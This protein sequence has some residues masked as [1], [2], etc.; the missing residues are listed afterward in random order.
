VLSLLNSV[1]VFVYFVWN[2][3]GEGVDGA[4][5]GWGLV[6]GAIL[7]VFFWYAVSAFYYL[8]YDPQQAAAHRRFG[9]GA[10]R[11]LV[12]PRAWMFLSD[13]NASGSFG[14]ALEDAETSVSF[15]WIRCCF[16]V[17]GYRQQGGN[18]YEGHYLA[19]VAGA[20]FIGLYWLLWPLTAPVPERFWATV[21]LSAY[22]VGALAV[23]IVVLSAKN[24]GNPAKLRVWK[25]LLAIPILGFAVAIPV[26]YQCYDAARFPILALVL[27]LAIATV[28]TLGALAFFLDRY[29]IPVITVILL[30]VFV[31]RFLHWDMGREEHYLSVTAQGPAAPLPTPADIVKNRLTRLLSQ[32]PG[33][34]TSQIQS[35]YLIV[36]TATGGGIHAA[37]WTTEVLRQL[38]EAFAQSPAGDFHDHLLLLSTVSGGS[39]GLYAYL[40][41]VAVARS[42]EKPDWKRM[43]RATKCSSLEAIGWGLVYFDVPKLTVPFGPYLW[44]LS[45]GVDDLQKASF[46]KDRT[47][48]LRKAMARNLNDPFCERAPKAENT[49]AIGDLTQAQ[50]R[51]STDERM[52]TLGQFNPLTGDDPPPAFSMNTTTAEYGA[53]FLSANYQMPPQTPLPYA[54]VP[55]ESF[56]QVYGNVSFPE[57][58]AGRTVDLPLATAAQLSA[59]FPYVSSAARFPFVDGLTSQHFVDGGY[60]DNDGTA[61][62]IEFLRAALDGLAPNLPKVR[63]LLVEIRNSPDPDPPT[64]PPSASQ[65]WQAWRSSPDSKAE[66]WNSANQVTAP[67]SAFYGAGHEST[68]ARNRNGLL[69]LQKAYADKLDLRH[70]VIDDQCA[71][72]D[73]HTDPL[74]WSL[75]PRQQREVER[76]ANLDFYKSKYKAVL[77]CLTGTCDTD[78]PAVI[79]DSKKS[80]GF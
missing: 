10:A 21:A 7:S 74:N 22:G 6:W 71:E 36:V 78:T 12:F 27:I 32:K 62:A 50:Q 16:P 55:A 5:M 73:V 34:A 30:S 53:R 18:L 69:L 47:W 48:A 52:L 39:A 57:F 40:R 14:D 76:T 61:S 60:Y 8:T 64:A 33:N 38:E 13:I 1:S 31:P 58:G 4:Q 11:T 59:T 15:N 54:P 80:C 63:I 66:L 20:G 70:I 29:R 43:T 35:P 24:E 17:P 41:E 19:L 28:W 44:G 9:E 77:S 67:L 46:G 79:P 51:S 2:G 68:T 49:L 72:N 65:T 23:Y 26:L 25:A 45:S 3:L 56:L 37:A 75:T 42:Q